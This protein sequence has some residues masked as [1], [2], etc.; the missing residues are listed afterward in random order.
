MTYHWKTV[1]RFNNM[2]FILDS[3]CKN[4]FY[5]SK[6]IL[7]FKTKLNQIK[8]FNYVI[9]QEIQINAVESVQRFL[10][11]TLD[12]NYKEFMKDIIANMKNNQKDEI[13]IIQQYWK[14]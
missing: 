4:Q 12:N 11:G 2:F 5:C 10:F 9:K 7:E 14:H 13:K 8:N 3:V 6:I 1:D